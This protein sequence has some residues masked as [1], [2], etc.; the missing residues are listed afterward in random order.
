VAYFSVWSVNKI[1]DSAD[2]QLKEVNVKWALILRDVVK[3]WRIDQVQKHKTTNVSYSRW[4]GSST[5]STVCPC[6]STAGI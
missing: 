6:Q 3:L 4:L 1:P 5:G 2:G